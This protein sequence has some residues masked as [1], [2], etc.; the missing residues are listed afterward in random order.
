MAADLPAPAAGATA[1]PAPVRFRRDRR[2]NACGTCCIPTAPIAAASRISRGKLIG[3]LRPI[4]PE[5][6]AWVQDEPVFD[7]PEIELRIVAPLRQDPQIA[8]VAFRP[9]PL[10]NRRRSSFIANC[11]NCRCS[12]RAQR[13]ARASA[14][15]A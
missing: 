12:R 15:V 13:F 7:R 9:R 8:E 14:I 5:Q 2:F 1:R 6:E 4:A 11:R 10:S 3:S